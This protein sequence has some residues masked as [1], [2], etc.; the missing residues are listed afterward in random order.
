MSFLVLQ[1]VKLTE[2]KVFLLLVEAENRKSFAA[3][4]ELAVG[5][6]VSGMDEFYDSSL[7]SGSQNGAG[8]S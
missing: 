2:K 8:L 7:P 1:S 4:S 3:G 6:V 5:H